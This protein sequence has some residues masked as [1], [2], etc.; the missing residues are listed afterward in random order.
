M[1]KKYDSVFSVTREHWIRW[2]RKLKP[3]GWD[4]QKKTNE[5]R[6]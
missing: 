4:I 2:N 3:D 5:T 1:M 6:Y